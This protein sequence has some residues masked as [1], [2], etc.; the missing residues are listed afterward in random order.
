MNLTLRTSILLILLSTW[1][2][3]GCSPPPNTCDQSTGLCWQNPQ[4]DA[5]D[6]TDTGVVPAQAVQYCDN[7]TLGGHDDW[8]LPTIDE[9]RTIVDGNPNTMPGGDC[10]ITAGASTSDGFNLA[11]LGA[12]HYQGPALFTGC[13]WKH[14]FGGTCDKPDPAVVG[15]PLETWA[16]NPASDD[17]EHWVSYITFDSAAMGFNHACSLGEVRCVRNKNGATPPSCEVNGQ[18]C[19][20]YFPS[21][22]HCD[23][24]LIAQADQ[25]ELTIHLPDQLPHQPYQLMAFLYEAEDFSFPPLGPPDGGTDYNQVI[26]PVIDLNQ[27]LTVTIPATSYYREELLAGHY[28]VFVELQMIEKFPPIPENG[29]YIWGEG[30]ASISFPLNGSSHST[31]SLSMDIQLEAVGCPESSPYQCGD[32]SCAMDASQCPATECATI[33][34]DSQVLSCRYVSLFNDNNCAD[35]PIAE[36]WTESWVESFCQSQD[37]AIAASVIVSTNN[38][39]LVEKGGYSQAARCTAAEQGKTWFSYNVPPAICTAVVG[40][41]GDSGPFCSNY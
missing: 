26:H 37:G 18:P 1:L 13:Y 10:Q 29:D 19:A 41:T 30:E 8:R 40:G 25:L 22:A 21:K 7:L 33:P 27:P 23:Q 36:G 28:Q 34:D 17:P 5:H 11:C 6:Y 3:S 24:D 32:G 39:C 9:L 2:F 31:S 38:S 14:L 35:F 16:L 20:S 4:K 12:E 15:H